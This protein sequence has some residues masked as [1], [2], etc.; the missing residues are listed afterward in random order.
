MA[1]LKFNFKFM[2]DK[3][4]YSQ[5]DLEVFK[6]LIEK[7]LERALEV[8]QEQKEIMTGTGGNG[9]DDTRKTFQQ[10]DA[11]EYA[12][13]QE[14]AIIAHKQEVFIDSLRN[15]L[16]RIEKGTYGICIKTGELIDRNRLLAVPN[17]TTSL[18]MKNQREEP[19]INTEEPL[20]E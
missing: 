17:T 5:E 7:K 1:Q 15:A 10:D 3:K 20:E 11:P 9:T 19:V 13:K 12:N 16:I 4:G 8:L 14:A 6:A 18:L 2:T